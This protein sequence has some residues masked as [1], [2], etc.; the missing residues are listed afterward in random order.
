M[1][2]RNSARSSHDRFAVTKIVGVALLGVF[3]LSLAG[4]ALVQG[5]TTSTPSA[6][7]TSAPLLTPAADL[8]EAVFIGDSYTHGAGASTPSARWT[9][10]VAEAEGWEEL[11][12]ALGGTGYLSTAGVSGCGKNYC[13]AYPERIGGLRIESPAV[14]VIAGGQNDFDDWGQDSAAVTSAITQTYTDARSRFPDARLIAVGP[15][16]LGDV[17]DS[18]RQLDDAVRA[19]SASVG[20]EY[21]SLLDPDALDAATMDVGDGGHVN[22]LG[23]RAIADR[24]LS[25]LG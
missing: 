18:A 22:D 15:S 3:S 17:I 7:Y 8:P 23:H 21:V 19:A 12:V 25:A 1:G 20:A 6:A 10:I 24:V 4:Y 13:P 16:I 9:T 5:E 2:K 14:V 11:N